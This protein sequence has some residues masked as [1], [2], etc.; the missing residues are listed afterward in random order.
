VFVSRTPE[1]WL[2]IIPKECYVSQAG[3][4]GVL[5]LFGNKVIVADSALFAE[6]LP[7]S[8]GLWW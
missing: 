4:R 7:G 2:R 3:L 5:I 6:K 1:N 8:V